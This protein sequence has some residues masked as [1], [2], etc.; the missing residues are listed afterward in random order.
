MDTA[1]IGTTIREG[2]VVAK[3]STTVFAD[4]TGVIELR[5]PITGRLRTLS[6]QRGKTVHPGEVIATIDPGTEQVW[7]ALRALYLIG[8]PDD[9]PTIR[10]YQR[11]VPDVSND[12]RQQAV[13]TEQAIRKRSGS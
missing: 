2:G 7:E 1:A 6:A 8:Q 11:D 5:S 12:V 9:L 10:P 4:G 13:E 3:I